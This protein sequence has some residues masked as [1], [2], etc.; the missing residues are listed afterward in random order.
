[1]KKEMFEDLLESVREAKAIMRG[2]KMPSRVFVFDE[3]N[4]KIIRDRF[5]LSQPQFAKLLGVSVATVRNWEQ[6]RC[7]PEGTARVLLLVAAKYP[8]AILNTIHSRSQAK[9][10]RSQNKVHARVDA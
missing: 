1:M 4:V 8:D 5:K 10:L 7:K 9:S 6:G 3:P 2:E